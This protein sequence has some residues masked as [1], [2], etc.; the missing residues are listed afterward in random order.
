VPKPAEI[1][2]SQITSEQRAI[3]ACTAIGVNHAAIGITDC[4]TQTMVVRG[5]IVHKGNRYVL[6]ETGWAVPKCWS[7]AAGRSDRSGSEQAASAACCSVGKGSAV[8][9]RPFPLSTVD[10]RSEN[11]DQSE[12]AVA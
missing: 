1:I 11:G 8:H 2:A 3:L 10:I 5:L 12:R 7:S 4:V 6:T 9:G